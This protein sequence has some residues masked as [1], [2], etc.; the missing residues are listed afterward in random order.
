MFFV[1]ISFRN[2]PI[3]ILESSLNDFP[4][5]LTKLSNSSSSIKVAPYSCSIANNI[6]KE[7]VSLLPCVNILNNLEELSPNLISPS[8]GLYLDDTGT[9]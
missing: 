9:T 8:N 2:V 6:K 4:N 3:S 5:A 7:L 1:I